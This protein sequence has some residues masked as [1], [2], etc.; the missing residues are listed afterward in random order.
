MI[1]KIFKEIVKI[2]AMVSSESTDGA[3]YEVTY[4]DSC[5]ACSC[6]DHNSRN[7]ICKHIKA[8]SKETGINC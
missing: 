3:Y 8:A 6:P 5:W 1:V 7:R 4:E 2:E